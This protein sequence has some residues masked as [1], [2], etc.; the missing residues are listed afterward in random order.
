MSY[1]LET[2]PAVALSFAVNALLL[3]A[4]PMVTAIFL[5]QTF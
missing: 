5:A 3:L 4:A 2:L 1:Q